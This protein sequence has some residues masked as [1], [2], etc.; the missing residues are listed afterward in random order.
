MAFAIQTIFL[1]C[2]SLFAQ[3]Q[4]E[5]AR[6]SPTGGS[7]TIAPFIVTG[8]VGGFVK[9]DNLVHGTVQLAGRLRNEYPSGVHIEVF[10]NRR[11]EKAHEEII[12]LL[13]TNH[14]ARLS[15]EEKQ[16]ARIIIYGMSWGASE[17][18][19]LARQLER[20]GIPVLLTIQVDS[21]AKMGE[22]D[23]LIPAN[24]SDAANFYQPNG[25]L[26]GRPKIRAADEARTR[27]LGN[28]RFDYKLKPVRCDKY[29][30][31]DRVF[32]KTH[33]EMECDPVVW[34]QVESLIRSKLPSVKP[35]G[36]PGEST[37]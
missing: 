33:T 35:S 31:Y 21:I 25:A 12:K 14:D 7:S 9:H 37:Q 23:E 17:A 36:L 10:E 28:F 20:D 29:P 11:R 18:V 16:D 13:D 34:N 1:L 30:W 32:A 5:A 3:G 15:S 26:H 2:S 6:L 27:I 4:N 24:V 19:M 8:F 22:S